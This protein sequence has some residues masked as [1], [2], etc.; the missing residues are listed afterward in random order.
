M[1]TRRKS[2][3]AGRKG[4]V[5][6]ATPRKAPTR[7]KGASKKLRKA[8]RTRAT[9]RKAAP[10]RKSL[11]R[12]A[13]TGRGAPLEALA[14]RIVQLTIRGE[15]H[16]P[17]Q[18][19]YAV[20]CT[21]TEPGAPPARGHRGLEEKLERWGQMQSRTTWTP[22]RVLTSDDAICIEWDARVHLRDGRVVSFS[23][24]AVHEIRGGKIA[25]ER[26]YYDPGAFAAPEAREAE[27][28][29]TDLTPRLF[30]DGGPDVDPLDL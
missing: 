8:P 20:D 28:T 9:R 19:L 4:A 10:S 29:T 27:Q 30:E 22:R 26:Y 13:A 11:A 14:R 6:K 17:L 23:E 12:K 15:M 5:H 2:K 18:E 24:V 21:S 16:L 7:K 3:T 25:N 1:A